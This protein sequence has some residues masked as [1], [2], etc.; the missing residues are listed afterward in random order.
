MT[1]RTG[2]W[3]GA[4]TGEAG[5]PPRMP[6]GATRQGPGRAATCPEVGGQAGEQPPLRADSLLG[7]RPRPGDDRLL[8]R[9]QGSLVVLGN[10]LGVDPAG[11]RGGSR[12]SDQ[13]SRGTRG[14]GSAQK[15]SCRAPCR[16]CARADRPGATV[17]EHP[18]DVSGPAGAMTP[19]L[20]RIEPDG[21]GMWPT[22]A[23]VTMAV[24]SSRRPR[25]VPDTP[26]RRRRKERIV[27]ADGV[28][29]RLGIR[30]AAGTRD[31][32]CATCVAAAAPGTSR[33]PT[34]PQSCR[35]SREHQETGEWV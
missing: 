12:A 26:R 31:A 17:V 35:D 21:T 20:R 9:K 10:G 18:R 32:C 11:P 34:T 19:A 1:E 8:G 29:A 28:S 13:A 6:F 4:R 16:R 3:P 23:P 27:D 30:D 33:N 25:A 5:R 22:R 2:V 24:L 7:G 15:G 14:S